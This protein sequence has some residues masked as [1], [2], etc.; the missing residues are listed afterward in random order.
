MLAMRRGLET[1][2]FAAV[3]GGGSGGFIGETTS[4]IVVE[5]GSPLAVPSEMLGGAGRSAE[6]AGG[7]ATLT[8]E[9]SNRKERTE[10]TCVLTVMGGFGRAG[11]GGVGAA[12]TLL[13]WALGKTWV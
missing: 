7:R 6:D 11:G 8:S 13:S 3:V 9:G 1:G 10:L 4:G 2:F 5:D 12:N